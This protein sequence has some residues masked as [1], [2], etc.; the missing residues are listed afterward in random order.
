MA[1]RPSRLE[2]RSP[3]R[4]AAA[5]PLPS[6]IPQPTLIASSGQFTHVHRSSPAGSQP[7]LAGFST[8]ASAVSSEATLRPGVATCSALVGRGSARATVAG[9]SPARNPSP[10]SFAACALR[11]SRIVLASQSNQRRHVAQRRRLGLERLL[12]L[13]DD[14]PLGHLADDTY[15]QLELASDDPPRSTRRRGARSRTS[16]TTRSTGAIRA[17]RSARWS[18]RPGACSSRRPSARPTRTSRASRT[19]RANFGIRTLAW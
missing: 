3:G 17:S 11:V 15:A 19:P 5:S 16:P 6:R 2:G 18:T 10:A 13:G 7:R 8:M 12:H 9:A 1:A 14:E 4:R